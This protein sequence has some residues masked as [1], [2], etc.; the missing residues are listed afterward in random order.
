MK[1]YTQACILQD[2]WDRQ[3]AEAVR[4]KDAAAYSRACEFTRL[5]REYGRAA[6]YYHQYEKAV[7]GIA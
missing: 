1:L 5:S 2:Y 6:N 3:A 7:R 4:Q